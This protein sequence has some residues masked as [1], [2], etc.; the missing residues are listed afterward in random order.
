MYGVAIV[1]SIAAFFFIFQSGMLS[2]LYGGC[3]E[4]Q[5]LYYLLVYG[6]ALLCGVSFVAPFWIKLY[7]LIIDGPARLPHLTKWL[8]GPKYEEQK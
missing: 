8:M 3:P 6:G 2:G 5:I 7:D 1:A 4:N